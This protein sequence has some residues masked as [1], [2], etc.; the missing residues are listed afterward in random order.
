MA[1][2]SLIGLVTLSSAQAQTAGNAAAGKKKAAQCAMCHGIDGKSKLPEAPNLAGQT[3]PYLVIA[4]NE[5]K[6]GER[7]NELMSLIAPKLS[8]QDIADLSAYYSS[9]GGAAPAQ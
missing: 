1:L 5:Y 7:K 2:T 8:D 6:S 9:L 4:L 3:Q